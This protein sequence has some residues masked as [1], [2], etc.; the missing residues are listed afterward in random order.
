[1]SAAAGAAGMGAMGGMAAAAGPATV[2]LRYPA[3][4][5]AF[6]LV[7]AGYCIWDLDQLSG[8]R[9]SLGTPRVSLAGV[10]AQGAP[11]PRV[12]LAGA[13]SASLALADPGAPHDSGAPH[14]LP[15]AA[16]DQAAGRPP[17]A[18]G[19]AAEAGRAE[20]A[21]DAFLLSPAITIACRVA[22]GFAMAFMLLIAI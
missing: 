10:A 8:R 9:Y 14:S 4:A 6:A 22:M 20:G 16:G 21:A 12:V 17:V 18:V 1:M 5:L 15:S 19:E 3:V 11:V 2:S 7:L 13:K